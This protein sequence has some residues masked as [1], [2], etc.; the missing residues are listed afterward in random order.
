MNPR[1]EPLTVAFQKRV[2]FSEVDGLGYV[3]HSNAAIWFEQAR[4]AY[5]RK[6]DVPVLEFARKGIYLAMR[7]LHVRYEEF[8]GYDDVIEVRVAL[9]RLLRVSCELHYR[10]DNLRTGKLAVRGSSGMVAVETRVPG[11]PPAIG[12]IRFDRQAFLPRVVSAEE[13]YSPSVN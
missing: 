10:V 8:I 7:D 6:F 12:R 11:A 3:H 9:T 13:L 2:T 5:F 4:E 1:I